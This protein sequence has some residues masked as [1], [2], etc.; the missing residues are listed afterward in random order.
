MKVFI[1][2][3][4]GQLGV[5]LIQAARQSGWTVTGVHRP[6]CDITDRQ[7]V[8]RALGDAGPIDAVINA[9]AYTA[10][11]RAESES[12]LAFAVNEQ[13][14][15]N[16]AQACREF[17]LPLIH[18]STDYVFN[19]MIT[20]PYLPS[21]PVSPLGIYGRSKAAGETAVCRTLRE[22]VIVRT[23][24]LFGLH[25]QNFVKTMLRVGKDRAELKVVD[26]QIGVPTYAADLAAA[27]MAVAG[28]IVRH[29]NGWGIHHYCNR[30]A[31]TWYAFAR[32]IFT[33]ARR[34]DLFAV[35]EIEPI[36]TSQYPL[37]APRPSYSVLDCTSIEKTFHV[38]RR[39]WEE[40]LDEMITTLFPDEA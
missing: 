19:G 14:A 11:D 10:V 12:D 20:R 29:K 32:R 35:R 25:G 27:L 34:Y 37:P 18:L 21:D 6:E 8:L 15:A 28:H 33:V 38:A 9:A 7:S 23:S 17:G 2:G 30:G 4:S 24:W 3:D 1:F 22:H 39:P 16:V 5:D 36:L 13:G 31:V 26:D 40:A